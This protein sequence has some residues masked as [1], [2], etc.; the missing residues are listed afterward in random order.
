MTRTVYRNASG[1]P[2]DN[3]VT[4]ARDQSTLAAT[5]QDR[6]RVLPLLL[7]CGVQYR[8]HSIRKP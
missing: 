4:T 6:F 7:D 3:Q 5:I 8:G 2:D 1:L